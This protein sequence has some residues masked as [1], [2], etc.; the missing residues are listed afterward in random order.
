MSAKY[1][2]NINYIALIFSIWK[3]KGANI[4]FFGMQFFK[5]KGCITPDY[6]PCAWGTTY[7]RYMADLGLETVGIGRQ[8][9]GYGWPRS[10]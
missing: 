8:A 3:I 5:D 9:G 10:R 6:L 2:C 1:E 7:P 4:S